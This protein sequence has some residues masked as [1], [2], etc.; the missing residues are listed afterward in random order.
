MRGII[1]AVTFLTA[2]FLVAA[3]HPVAVQEPSLASLTDPELEQLSLAV[4]LAGV[5]LVS[6]NLFYLVFCFVIVI[7]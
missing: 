2:L 7:P 5:Y 6:D 3:F 4:C 1:V